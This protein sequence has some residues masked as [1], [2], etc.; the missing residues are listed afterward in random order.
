MGGF[1][2]AV[3]AGVSF[4]IGSLNFNDKISGTIGK[5][6]AHGTSQGALTA[7]QGGKFQHGF[8]SAALTAGLAPDIMKKINSTG[9]RV[10]ASSVVGGTASVLGGGKFANGAITGAY[11]MLFNEMMHDGDGKPKK[12]GWLGR[13]IQSRAEGD[14]AKELFENFWNGGGD[15]TLTDEQFADIASLAKI[16]EEGGF[17]ERNGRYVKY[18]RVSFYG[19][20]YAA[21]FGDADMYFDVFGRPVGFSDTYD[22][23]PYPIRWGWGKG[24]FFDAQLKTEL[25]DMASWFKRGAKGFNINY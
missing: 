24:G 9:G 23:N 15:I 2:G 7:A 13:K 17:V 18:K 20:K 21:A 6:L 4:G 8:F 22:F 14:Y 10:L 16:K 11:V 3:G 1:W 5:M 25:V 12:M 19:T